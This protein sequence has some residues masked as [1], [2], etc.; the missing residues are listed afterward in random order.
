MAPPPAITTT[1]I[2]SAIVI[3]DDAIA[4]AGGNGGRSIDRSSL[5]TS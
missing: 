5:E 4:E 3:L 2:D 1:E